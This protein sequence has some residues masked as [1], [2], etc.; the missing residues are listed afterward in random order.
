MK[1]RAVRMAQPR[2]R[3][4]HLPTFGD[5]I[6]S[7]FGLLRGAAVVL[8]AVL[9]GGL[10][11]GGTYALWNS[12]AV[13]AG[14]TIRSGTAALVAP[15]SLT[16]APAVLYPGVSNYASVVVNNTGDVALLLRLAAMTGPTPTSFSGALTIGIGVVASAGQC[17]AGSFVPSWTGTFASVTPGSIGAAPVAK[18][19]TATVCVSVTL[20]ENAAAGQQGSTAAFALTLAGV[21]P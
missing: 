2:P 5:R 4:R 18:G 6:S 15:S 21:Q 1:A 7:P 17:A 19:S 9:I 13:V 14:A 10:A 3:H 11:T 20:A 8:G 12:S 16:F